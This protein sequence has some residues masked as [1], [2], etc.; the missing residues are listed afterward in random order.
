MKKVYLPPLQRPSFWHEANKKIL[1]SHIFLKLFRFFCRSQKRNWKNG[2]TWKVERVLNKHFYETIVVVLTAWKLLKT[3]L[4]SF[5]SSWSFFSAR[6]EG[7]KRHKRHSSISWTNPWKVCFRS[8][9]NG[10]SLF[11]TQLSHIVS[12][13]FLINNSEEK[14]VL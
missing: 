11:N 9:Q 12:P 8:S 4:A 1:H 10:N 2:K 6:L 7:T 13:S 14:N 3:F 5:C